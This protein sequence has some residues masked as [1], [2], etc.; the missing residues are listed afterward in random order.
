MAARLRHGFVFVKDLQ[1]MAT[2]YEGVFGLV[3]EPQ[4][5]PGFLR[6]ADATG[7]GVALHT[8]PDAIRDQ[9]TLDTPPRWREDTAYKLTFETDDLDGTRSALLAH[10][11]QA[12]DPW[13]WSG[14]RY[15]ECVDPEG[16]V[17]QLYEAPTVG[18]RGRSS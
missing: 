9:I 10:G 3:R 8:L 1:T 4:A 16:N 17:V 15:C 12:K 11:G 2:F 7:S 5:D 14:A 18:P 13:A 6:L